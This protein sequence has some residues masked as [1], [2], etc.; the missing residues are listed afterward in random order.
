ML[1]IYYKNRVGKVCR[2]FRPSKGWTREDLINDLN[3]VNERYGGGYRA[4]A[5]AIR[6]KNF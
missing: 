3:R 2:W 6:N 4:Y 5:R 1:L